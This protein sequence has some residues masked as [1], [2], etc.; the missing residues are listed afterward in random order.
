[1]FKSTTFY[2]N[3]SC[4]VITGIFLFHLAGQIEI[5]LLN[6]IEN[7]VYDLRLRFSTSSTID[8][9]IV[10]FDIDEKSLAQEGR[11]PW[12]RDK[13]TYLVDIMFDYYR[14]KVLGFDIVFSEPDTS[15]GLGLLEKLAQEELADDKEF[16]N[17]LDQVRPRL[18]F[19]DLFARSLKD[20][21][22]VLGFYFNQARTSTNPD[23]S[24]PFSNILL[25]DHPSLKP[26]KATGYGANLQILQNAAIY[27]GYFNNQ[28]VDSDGSYRR[29]PLITAYQGKIYEALS[30]AV[31]RRLLGQPDLKFDFSHG[32]GDKA[33]LESI[34]IE[35]LSIPVT[36]NGTVLVPYRGKQGSFNYISATDLLNGEVD[37][38]LLADKIV[39]VGT[40]APGLLDLRTTPV[41]NVYPGVEI[42]ANLISS[43]LDDNF[44]SKPTYML[45]AE[46]IEL[47]L[48]A[49]FV[50]FLYPKL[51]SIA[52]ALTFS[53]LILLMISANFYLW[54]V[55]NI[56]NFLATPLIVLFLLFLTQMY[57]GY[58]L[59]TRKKNKLGKIFGQ[60]IPAELVADMSKTE[61][62]FTLKGESRE[63]T[64]L[65]SD[66]RG[67]TT[68][69][70]T[71]EPEQLS[72]LINEILTP[73]TKMIHHNKGTIDKY[74]GDAVMAF[75]GAPLED[76]NHAHNAVNAALEF[77]HV[78]ESINLSFQA[79][80]WP[81]IDMGIGVNTGVMSVGNMGS[82]FRMAYTVMGD[83]V[84]LGSRLEGLTK[85]YGVRVIVGE[86]TKNAAPE[87]S[88]V[89]VDRVKVKG[90][91]EPVTIYEPL[92]LSQTLSIEDAEL[93][94]HLN[95]AYT[96]YHSRNWRDAQKTFLALKTQFPQ[97]LL[98]D[99]YLDRIEQYIASPPETDWDGVFTHQTK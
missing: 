91:N 33:R 66:V 14:I 41:Q 3:L 16:G 64:V 39:L 25:S 82:E 99:I 84:N 58:F 76:K 11:W 71:L 17:V 55:L 24:L 19:D 37:P 97:R 65:F 31:Y 35:S 6:R 47:I 40:T 52:A 13:M 62:E 10:I 32:Y 87:F 9:R 21:A 92:G 59:E 46:F 42:H 51:S 23:S 56:D 30:L 43:M 85:Q 1:M 12:S 96:S 44:R 60:Y 61:H 34:T 22:V 78:L 2:R 93:I 77:V 53:L 20:R 15:S 69:S 88:Y 75:W 27:G 68:I 36:E 7:I 94:Q 29:V 4:L 83:A 63:M 54:N 26:L 81:A 79:K 74:I 50:M 89:E 70:E 72:D 80:A 73:V 48:L 49:G 57:F 38:E 18:D 86:T 90:K 8:P 98:F 67:F 5:P 45:G 28:S 95:D